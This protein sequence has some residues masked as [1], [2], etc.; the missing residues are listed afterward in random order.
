MMT[1]SVR[2]DRLCE[3]H[4]SITLLTRVCGMIVCQVCQKQAGV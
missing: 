2:E 1:F 4:Y 3:S